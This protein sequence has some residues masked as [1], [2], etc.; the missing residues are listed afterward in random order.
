M[1]FTTEIYPDPVGGVVMVN[2]AV[3]RSA[4]AG[5][6]G[7]MCNDR[8]RSVVCVS[9]CVFVSSF[10]PFPTSFLQCHTCKDVEL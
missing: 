2:V 9:L 4:M 7:I 6:S 3:F 1:Y 10:S 5:S 8:C